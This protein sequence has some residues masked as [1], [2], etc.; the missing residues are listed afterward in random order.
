MPRAQTPPFPTRL[1]AL[2]QT[3]ED[4]LART[5]DGL[6]RI[7]CTPQVDLDALFEALDP[8]ATW[9][10]GILSPFAYSGRRR[11]GVSREPRE[12]ARWRNGSI[13]E[14]RANSVV[15][16]GRAT[17]REEAGL[18]RIRTVITE[19][20]VLATYERLGRKWLGTYVDKTHAP[21]RLF[22][23][24][25]AM[26]RE[27]SIDG[28]LLSDLGTIAFKDA[29]KAHVVPQD[30]L[31]RVHLI[32]DNR[33]QDSKTPGVR[34][35]L[36][37]ALAQFLRSA[38]DSAADQ[39]KWER[40]QQRADTGDV[41][42][43]AALQ[44]AKTR[45]REHLAKM[46]LD[47]LLAALATKKPEPK[48]PGTPGD[49]PP[50]I[51]LD[52][53]EFLDR[54]ADNTTDVLQRVAADLDLNAE[55]ETVVEVEADDKTNVIFTAQVTA[56]EW[57]LEKDDSQVLY[58]LRPSETDQDG[59]KQVTEERLR[60]SA[61]HAALLVTSQKPKG[62]GG[63]SALA[64]LVDEYLSARRDAIGMA[65][66]ASDL[67]AV[68]IL[69]T[70]TLDAADRYLGKW[71]ALVST[72]LSEP[73]VAHTK[74]LREHLILL[75]AS[76]EYSEVDG[77]P[78]FVSCQLCPLH[79]FVLGPAVELA[80]FVLEHTGEDQL[81]NQ[82][83]WALDRSSP[84]YP[85]V[86]AP[87]A[88]LLLYAGGSSWPTFETRP[89]GT[90]RPVT[91]AQGLLDVVRSYLGLHPYAQRWLSILLIDPPPGPGIPGALAAIGRASW[92]GQD[93]RGDDSRRRQF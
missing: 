8:Q 64:G 63:V 47:D 50:S 39:R 52:V 12:I 71:R 85:A 83:L 33:A 75:D 58:T 27:Q 1:V 43:L 14:R 86:W 77:L 70:A 9:R 76:W 65:R 28:N 80:R 69:D 91:R 46:Q 18:R 2:A 92:A 48:D 82:V 32:P 62:E 37:H 42:A 36:N 15:V 31:W 59:A 78:S 5:S 21:E 35:T 88:K 10:F 26:A 7:D 56:L 68:L 93:L 72:V 87:D 17:G 79:P 81:G 20:D 74:Q 45:K 22:T 34:L 89:R 24:L 84:A 19:D 73:E 57:D 25:A 16:F 23:A 4:A 11:K 6:I 90:R 60:Q 67:L 51:Q 54:G 30:E 55:D 49:D 53:F 61:Q 13:A 38:V 3:I 29:A 66:W 40:L 44:Y 41:V